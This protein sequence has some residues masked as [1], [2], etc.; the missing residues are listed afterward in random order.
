MNGF[1]DTVTIDN[2]EDRSPKKKRQGSSKVSSRQNTTITRRISPQDVRTVSALKPTIRNP[3][4]DHR[5]KR[6]IVELAIILTSE[7]KFDEFTQALMSFLSN[8]QMVD[9]KFVINPLNPRSESNDI[10]TK[11][12]I[13]PNVTRLGEHIKI[14][15]NGTNVFNRRK[16]WDNTSGG[17][18]ARKSTKKEEFQ[19][20]TVYFRCLCPRR[21][22]PRLLLNGLH[23]NGLVLMEF[24]Y[25][26]RNY[27]LLTVRR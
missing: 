17:C 12:D 2:G 14:S 15:G 8:A 1:E 4:F 10:V 20:P 27:N 25:R 7:K 19:D 13:S 24:D 16:K 22:H 5:Y 6:T 21:F 18:M 9:S 26:S 3:T 23:T 11:G